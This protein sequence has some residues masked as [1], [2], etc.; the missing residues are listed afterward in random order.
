MEILT[1]YVR[2]NARWIEP[3]RPDSVVSSPADV[4]LDQRLKPEE[5]PPP[6]TDIQAILT[7]FNAKQH[8]GPSLRLRT[9]KRAL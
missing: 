4:P 7:G 6:R 3:S 2:E 1:A 8:H 5:L 9:G